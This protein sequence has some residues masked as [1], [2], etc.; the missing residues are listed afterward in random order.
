MSVIRLVARALLRALCAVAPVAPH[1]SALVY[2]RAALA[3]GR[4]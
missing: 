1:Q 2:A 4:R 3:R